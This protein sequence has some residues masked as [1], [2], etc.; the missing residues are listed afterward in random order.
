MVYLLCYDLTDLLVPVCLA[1]GILKT[2]VFLSI[3]DFNLMIHI[4][5]FNT[6]KIDNASIGIQ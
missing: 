2:M 4:S 1:L 3:S 5:G 6:A